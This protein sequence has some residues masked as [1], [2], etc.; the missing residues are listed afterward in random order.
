M[1]PRLWFVVP[2]AGASRRMGAALPKQYLRCRGRTILEWA[3]APLLAHPR[4]AGGAVALAADDAGWSGLPPALRERVTTTTGGRERADS[5]LA[6]LRALPAADD[7]WVLVHDAARPCLPRA[8]LDRLIG[9]CERDAVGGL[10][11]LPV[12]D[13]LKRADGARVATTVPREGLWR[14]LTPQMF[15]RG[16]LERALGAAAGAGGAPAA[17]AAAVERLGERP[18]LVEGSALNIK[19]TRPSD[20]ALVEACL[21][22]VGEDA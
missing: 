20:L 6:G 21:A 10:L 5:V 3:L 16:L 17:A 19:V 2:A 9:A 4:L 13:T 18:L 7:D 8:D 14:A 22:L 12:A 11:A 1:T 15:R